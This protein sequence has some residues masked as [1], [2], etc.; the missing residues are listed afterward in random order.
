M[1]IFLTVYMDERGDVQ[2][3]KGSDPLDFHREVPA[4]WALLYRGVVE[5]SIVED[6]CNDGWNGRA[7][8]RQ[9]P[10]HLG[11]SVAV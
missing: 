10:N 7:D 5:G 4:H 9:P 11:W 3:H 6:D 8:S 1:P 2:A